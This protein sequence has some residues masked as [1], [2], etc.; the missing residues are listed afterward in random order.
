MGSPLM[1]EPALFNEPQGAGSYLISSPDFPFPQIIHLRAIQM[2]VAKLTEPTQDDIFDIG[3][4]EG[5]RHRASSLKEGL[6]SQ[7]TR[8]KG[9]FSCLII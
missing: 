6:F 1:G 2:G 9:T 3:F 8:P 7:C 4:G 5:W